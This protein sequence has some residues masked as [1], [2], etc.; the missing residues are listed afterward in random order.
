[1]VDIKLFRYQSIYC[2]LSFWRSLYQICKNTD[3]SR[4]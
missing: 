1:M 3:C 2:E 4:V